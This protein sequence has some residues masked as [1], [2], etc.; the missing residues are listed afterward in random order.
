MYNENIIIKDWRYIDLSFGLIYPNHYNIGISSYTIRLLYYLINLKQQFACERIFLPKKI[1]F[2]ASKDQSSINRIRS[3]ENKVLPIDFDVLGFSLHYENDFKNV[4]WILEKAEIPITHKKRVEVLL[5]DENEL[6]IIIGGGPAI[7]SNPLPLSKFFDIFFIGDSEQNLF[8]FFEI[9]RE[10]KD[11]KFSFMDLLKNCINIEGVYVPSLKNSV[12]R[13]VLTDLDKSP[14]PVFQL[15]AK[16]NKEKKIFE[17]NFFVEINRGCPF[18]C[19]FCISSYHNYPFR[20]RSYD[21]IIKA[22]DD[23]IK[24]LEFNKI[25]LI[26]SCVSSHPRFYKILEDII[27][28]GKEFSLPSIRLDHITRNL[29]DLF[30]KGNVKTITIAPEAGSESLRFRL[31]K[32]ISNRKIF[33]VLELIKDSKL[34]SIKF[35]FLVGL[36]EEND[37]DIKEIITFLKQID[38][39]GFQWNSLKVNIN[40]FIPKF[41]TPYGDNVYYYLSDNIKKLLAKFQLLEKELKNLSSIKLKFHNPKELVNAA[42]I[43]T[44]FSLGDEDFSNFLL[45]FYL[46]GANMAALRRLE[47][48][49]DISLDKYFYKIQDGYKPWSF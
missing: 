46:H 8:K 21:N 48:E 16:S 37:E 19:K 10:F 47:K 27:K 31:G 4:L 14:I 39:I 6:P 20:N 17:E 23:A 9:V 18:Q 43:Q 25:S 45:K 11:R 3:I 12:K 24:I 49:P 22:I 2:P 44:I 36:P 34:K 30:E 29:I 41:N 35:Y 13:V 32:K 42:K 15:I 33:E 38:E 40:P 7:T 1:K 28:R 26:G 5:R